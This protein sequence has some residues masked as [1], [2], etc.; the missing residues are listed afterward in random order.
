[1]VGAKAELRIG[2]ALADMSEFVAIDPAYGIGDQRAHVEALLAAELAADDALADLSIE[3][4]F[5]TFSST[6]IEHKRAVADEFAADGVLAVLG[7]RDFTYGSVRLA[8]THGVPV[9]DVNAIPRELFG[10]TDPWMFTIRAAQDLVYLTY[11][12]WAHSAGLRI[13]AG[14]IPA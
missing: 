8:E 7:A 11:V 4:V 3:L 5:R 2:I 9:I 12:D 1:M 13:C 10:R 14:P 6:S